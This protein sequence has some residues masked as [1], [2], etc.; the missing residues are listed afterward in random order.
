MGD[1][2]EDGKDKRGQRG[3]CS[4]GEPQKDGCKEGRGEN[5]KAGYTW[6]PAVKQPH[7]APSRGGRRLGCRWWHRGTGLRNCIAAHLLQHKGDAAGALIEAVNAILKI[8]E[9][10][11]DV[12]LEC[13]HQCSE[14]PGKDS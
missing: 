14:R 5:C 2:S 8:V 9:A 11:E 1:R 6:P 4:P 10:A 13:V 3:A 7:D 12:E